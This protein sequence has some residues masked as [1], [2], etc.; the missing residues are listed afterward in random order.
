MKHGKRACLLSSEPCYLTSVKD[1]GFILIGSSL[2]KHMLRR[3]EWLLNRLQLSSDNKTSSH[4]RWG[5][6]FTSTVL[7]FG[8]L[9]LAQDQ[10]LAS[11]LARCEATDQHILA[12]ANSNSLVKS[13]LVTRLNL[14]RFMDLNLHKSPS[15]P[16]PELPSADYLKMAEF[17]AHTTA[18]AG[19]EEQLRMVSPPR[20][21]SNTPQQK[22][23]REHKQQRAVSFQFPHD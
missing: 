21:Y 11:W 6:A 13:N 1:T 20:A 9:V 12:K 16:P 18:K 22:A 7:P 5:I 14:D 10:S 8:E 3:A 19:G 4:R 23:I 15:L 2:G 17:G